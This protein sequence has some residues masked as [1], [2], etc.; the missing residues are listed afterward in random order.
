MKLYKRRFSLL[1]LCLT[2]L[3]ACDQKKV[4][5]LT[6][7]SDSLKVENKQLESSINDMLAS[8]NQIQENLNEIKRR[9]GYIQLNT[10]E[11]IEIDIEASINKDIELIELDRSIII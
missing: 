6:E 9:E 3:F 10:A 11:D 2:V 4:D 8:F 1:L 7:Q 5:E